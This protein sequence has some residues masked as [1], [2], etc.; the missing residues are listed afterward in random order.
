MLKKTARL[1]VSVTLF[2]AL[3]VRTTSLPNIRFA[4]KTVTGAKPTPCRA[5]VCGLLLALSVTVSVPALL[6][7][8]VGVNVI[9]DA[10][11]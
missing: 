8:A 1:F 7:G 3:V 4:G 2:G 11:H 6:P 5:V 9:C 10:L